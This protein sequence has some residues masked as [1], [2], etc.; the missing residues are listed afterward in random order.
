MIA[1]E[2]SAIA[3]AGVIGGMGTST[4]EN[5]TEILLESAFFEPVAISGVARSYGLHTE[6]SLRFERGD[7]FNMAHHAMER[8]TELVLEICG[9]TASGI[10]ETVDSKSLPKLEPIKISIEKIS[11]VL[12]F[13]ID[14]SWVES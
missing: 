4:L 10:N 14:L 1:D 13:D 6:A 9:G 11:K 8:A 12:G 2:K 3:I 7:D 5:S